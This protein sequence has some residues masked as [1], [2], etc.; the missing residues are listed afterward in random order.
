MMA[1]PATATTVAE[2]PPPEDEQPKRTGFYFVVLVVLLALLV[3][4]LVLLARQLGVGSQAKVDVPQVVGRSEADATRDLTDVGLKVK[5]V[6][7]N[8]DAVAGQV[9]DQNPKPAA[10][11]KK[12]STVTIR[13]SQGPVPVDVPDVRNR[14]VDTAN[15]LLTSRGFQVTVQNRADDKVP[16]DVVIDQD[17]KGGGQAPRGSTVT[18]I[19]STGRE[20]VAVPNVVGRDQSEAANILGQAGFTTAVIVQPSDTVAAGRVIRT[21]PA[22]PT[23]VAKGSTVTLIVSSG[24]TSTTSLTTPTTRPFGTTTTTRF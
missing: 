14:K 13:V 10:K 21:D 4:V 18:L 6:K 12:G 5:A 23:P 20:Q 15:D 19:V 16:V 3:G 1:G 24:G 9:F 7:E 2:G 17:P 22:P 11:L 8:N